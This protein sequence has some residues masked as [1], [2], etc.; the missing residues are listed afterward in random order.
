MQADQSGSQDQSFLIQWET[1]EPAFQ[2]VRVEDVISGLL[3]RQ[4]QPGCGNV[5]PSVVSDHRDVLPVSGLNLSHQQISDPGIHSEEQQD[6]L[7]DLE[8]NEVPT[9]GSSNLDG[10][11]T[12]FWYGK[13]TLCPNCSRRI[14]NDFLQMHQKG[15]KQ[16]EKIKSPFETVPELTLDDRAIQLNKF[17][18]LLLT[19]PQVQEFNKFFL[20][21]NFDVTEP[22]FHSWLSLKLASIP[23]EFEA[24]Q[25][26]L[27][28]HTATNIP[29][30]KQKRKQNLPTGSARYDPTSDQWVAILKEQE[31]KKAGSTAKRKKNDN[32]KENLN[33]E[34]IPKVTTSAKKDNQAAKNRKTAKA[35]QNIKTPQ[36]SKNTKIPQSS[37]TPQVAKIIKTSQ[38]NQTFKTPQANQTFKTPQATQNFKTP[39]APAP[40]SEE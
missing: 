37:R 25:R 4:N 23:S 31:S 3:P 26:V 14:S 21:K 18:V 13:T 22:L 27:S 38:G 19:P 16:A 6:L 15:C 5:S 30:N 12:P 1:S 36:T 28:A 39:R 32:Q 24:L 29:K 2:P 35:T 40:Q 33:S 17:E 11:E 9:I 34:P 7:L 8:Q 20:Q 10:L